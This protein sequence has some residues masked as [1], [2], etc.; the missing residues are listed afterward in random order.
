M[1]VPN[2][3]NS[4]NTSI[5]HPRFIASHAWLPLGHLVRPFNT[6]E[7]LSPSPFTPPFKPP[8]SSSPPPTG[9]LKYSLKASLHTPSTCPI[10][11][12]LNPQTLSFT[13]SGHLFALNSSSL[14]K[15][16]TA[17]LL[18]RA[19]SCRNPNTKLTTSIPSGISSL[20]MWIHHGSH[21]CST[22]SSSGLVHRYRR[23][24]SATATNRAK[25]TS[26][27]TASLRMCAAAS[28]IPSA[29]SSSRSACGIRYSRATLPSPHTNPSVGGSG[30]SS[31]SRS[32]SSSP[33]PGPTSS[34]LRPV[35]IRSKMGDV[36]AS[37]ALDTRNL[38]TSPPLLNSSTA[39]PAAEITT[40]STSP[41]LPSSNPQPA[42]PLCN[43]LAISIASFSMR[44][45]FRNRTSY[46]ALENP[47][48]PPPSIL[49]LRIS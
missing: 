38:L 28:R 5:N 21:R 49:A 26:R 1:T 22:T 4:P 41:A 16:S 45:R 20:P 27:G 39:S 43:T 36:S 9:P 14:L 19:N 7:P 47:P 17:V 35:N 40:S 6:A 32:A 29:P 2:S 12:S 31:P 44:S 37:I 18:I 24:A 46:F 48:P 34:L 3:P 25:L 13:L 10:F 30:G 42:S 11:T 23:H 33:Q 8:F 15:F